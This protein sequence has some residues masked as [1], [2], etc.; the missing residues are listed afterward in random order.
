MDKTD[1][2]T[3][4]LLIGR[5][6][7]ASTGRSDVMMIVS[8]NNT[9]KTI[10]LT[11]LL[12]DTYVSIPVNGGLNERLNAAHFIGGVSL[13]EATIKSNFGITIDNYIEV[14]FD[15]ATAVFDRI[16]GLDLTLSKGECEYLGIAASMAGKPIH[17]N[18]K[19][20][21]AHCRNRSVTSTEA[22]RS[23]D[24]SRTY[25][26]RQVLSLA[27]DKLKTM[28]LSDLYRMLDEIFPYVT[29]DI[30]YT[31]FQ[32]YVFKSPQFLK[33]KIQTTTIPDVYWKYAHSTRGQSVIVITSIERIMNKWEQLVYG[34]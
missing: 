11:S 29:T 23:G 33:Y 34:K 6:A 18:G 3:H 13:L 9:D 2:V 12:R 28:S 7:G 24:W 14:N 4:I 31:T 1:K 26:Q 15:A 25:R 21:L 32:S 17:L 19:Q 30:K 20:L 27:F 22:G 5:D 8:I 10:T 16:G